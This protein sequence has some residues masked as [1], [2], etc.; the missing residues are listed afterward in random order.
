MIFS[1]NDFC[2]SMSNQKNNNIQKRL[3]PLKLLKITNTYPKKELCKATW[4]FFPWPIISPNFQQKRP[5]GHGKRWKNW[6]PWPWNLGLRKP[7]TCRKM[8]S[9][10]MGSRFFEGFV[11][12]LF[13]DS[14]IFFTSFYHE[15]KC[16]KMLTCKSAQKV[17]VTH[18]SFVNC[19]T[20]TDLLYRAKTYF[21]LA[22]MLPKGPNALKLASQM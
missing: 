8:L 2:P 12:V 14:M 22:E 19:T 6:R 18:C 20:Q 10:L 21:L 13:A 16:A 1:P 5:V 11:G 9:Q 3:K 15:E 7:K 4:R 17:W